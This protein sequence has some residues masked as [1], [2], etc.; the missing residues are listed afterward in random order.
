[1][2]AFN[3]VALR[4]DLREKNLAHPTLDGTAGP[5]GNVIPTAARVTRTPDGR[6]N[7]LTCPMMGAAGT[8]FGRN[9]PLTETRPEFGPDLLTPSPRLI[10]ARLLARRTFMPA[11]TLNLL[12]AAWIQFQTH[13]WFNHGD[14]EVN[15]PF[16]IALEDGDDWHERPMKIQRTRCDTTRTEEEDRANLPPT[17]LNTVSHWW[18]GSAVYGS[19]ATT[20]EMLRSRQDGKLRM[21]DRRLPFDDP[22]TGIVS[23][24]FTTNWWVGLELLHTIF[25]LE[26][27]AICDRLKLE[28][29][30]WE[31]EQLFQTARLIN[32]ALLAKIHTVEWTPAIL[33]HPALRIGMNANWWGLAGERLTRLFGRVGEGEILSGIPG[34]PTDHH[35]APFALTEEFVSVY[36]MHPLLPDNLVLR[37]LATGEEIKTFAFE[38]IVREK[39][40]N[41]MSGDVSEEDVLYS[42]G[43]AN[44]GAL[45]LRNYPNFL[46]KFKLPDGNIVDLGAIDIMR[47]RERGVPRYNRFRELLRLPRVKS[48]ENLTPDR[49]L[50]AELSAVYGGNI[51]RLDLMVGMFAETPPKGFGFSDTAFRIFIL[52]ASRRIKSDRYFTRDFSPRIYTQ[53]GLNWIG[54]NDMTSII[55]RHY[56]ELKPALQHSQNAF[57]PWQRTSSS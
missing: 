43:V 8:R 41:V 46:R 32:A 40:R 37:R 18:D 56:P 45:I 2:G 9:F 17:Y 36:R 29:P 27:N 7:D 52:M 13:D 39:S 44:P 14:N 34:S 38:D 12:A 26:H 48:F 35:A 15:N 1:M 3:L 24:G 30:N 16:E 23:T 11:P 50:A 42:F 53:V 49:E 5:L 33:G 10:S 25:A 57:A 4:T 19:E 55:L 51:D 21:S 28:F 31:D 22:V 54:E 20:I 47:D 6:Y